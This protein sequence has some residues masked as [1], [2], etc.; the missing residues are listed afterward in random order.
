MYNSTYYPKRLGTS[1]VDPCHFDTDPAGSTS[2]WSS[3]VYFTFL[4][5]R[6][7]IL[8]LLYVW[9]GDETISSLQDA[10]IIEDSRVLVLS[11]LW[12]AVFFY[13]CP[14]PFWISFL[15]FEYGSRSDRMIGIQQG[16]GLDNGYGSTTLLGTV[17]LFY[18]RRTSLN[19]YYFVL[20]YEKKIY[21]WILKV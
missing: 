5:K 7:R 20:T 17:L 13:C 8:L 18:V 4:Q 2:L 6:L 1:V 9:V 12:S 3:P 19:F 11:F 16:L 15:S 21:P 14:D 10:R